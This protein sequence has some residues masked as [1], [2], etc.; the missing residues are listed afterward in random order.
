MSY[1]NEN[2]RFIV[3][4]F[5]SFVVLFFSA[6]R[7]DI[8][9]NW[10][11]STDLWIAE[12]SYNLGT[13]LNS[14]FLDLVF[15]AENWQDIVEKTDKLINYKAEIER[16]NIINRSLITENNYL[17]NILQF[18]PDSSFYKTLSARVVID[19]S[20]AFNK[21]LLV[22]HNSSDQLAVGQAVVFRGACIGRLIDVN[23]QHSRILL[24]SD[25]K[26]K[27]PVSVGN[28]KHQAL[29]VGNN[30]NFLRLVLLKNNSFV[31]IGDVVNT[32][33]IGKIM[34]NGMPVGVVIS[35]TG[36][37][38]LVKPY[39]DIDDVSY[40]NIIYYDNTAVIKAKPKRSKSRRRRR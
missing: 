36:A 35:V 21:S 20:N 30:D 11:D 6:V 18:V 9:N 27:I 17:K 5:L 4:L 8:V 2:Y 40:V 28:K 38:I 3:Y 25:T 10:R 19:N 37:E 15:F 24:L 1:K 34:P 16:L 13:K 29:V 39:V 31:K 7:T 14:N 32:S 12:N 33:G 26:S 22:L 23:K